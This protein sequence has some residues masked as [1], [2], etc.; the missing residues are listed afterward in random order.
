MWVEHKESD[1]Q[2]DFS[3]E[4]VIF[5]LHP[6]TEVNALNTVGEKDK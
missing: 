6:A 5:V 1:R 2:N 4:L 3:L